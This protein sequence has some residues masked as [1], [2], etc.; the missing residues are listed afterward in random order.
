MLTE[1]Q[2]DKKFGALAMRA[3]TYIVVALPLVR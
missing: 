1:A 2:L 3:A